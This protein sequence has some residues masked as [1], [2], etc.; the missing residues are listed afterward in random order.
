MTDFQLALLVIGALAV[1]GVLLYNRLQERAAERRA[2][3]D[4]SSRHADALME[5]APP[6]R[7]E[8]TLDVPERRADRVAPGQ[9]ESVPDARIDYVMELSAARPVPAAELCEAWGGLERRFGVRTLLA[10][11]D[12]EAWRALRPGDPGSYG[13]LRAGLQM[14]SRSGTA[15][16]AE[17]IEFRSGVE[18]L[19]AR[20]NASVRAPDMRQAL[21]EAKTLDQFC[22]DADIQIAVRVLRPGGD[23]ARSEAG[24]AIENAGLLTVAAGRHVMRDAAGHTI[25]ELVEDSSSAESGFAS[26]TLTLDVPRAP[27][28]GRAY[29]AM[30]RAARHIAGALGAALVDDNGNALEERALEAIALEVETVRRALQ[31]RGLETGGALALRLF[32]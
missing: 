12:G 15:G 22:A 19:A 31:E 13:A 9:P 17:L 16:E 11:Q 32:S 5:E 6:A 14:V 30:V 28:A 4:F 26:L 23:L 20:W 10:C 21:E 8:P 29:A 27:E 3:R 25:F 7:R 24:A 1:A 2:A 18:T